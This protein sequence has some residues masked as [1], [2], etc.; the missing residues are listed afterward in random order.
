[1]ADEIKNTSA[2]TTAIEKKSDSKKA[3]SDKS[4]APKDKKPNIFVRMGKSIKKFCK[5]LKGECKKVVWPDRKTVLK[6]SGVVLVSVVVLGLIIWGI[7]TGLSELIKLLVNTAENA[8]DT[9][10]TTTAAANVAGS[11]IAGF[12]GA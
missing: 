8:S 10:E 1:M 9:A 2:E 5:D 7:D 6:S 4:N 12:F 11:I 3:K